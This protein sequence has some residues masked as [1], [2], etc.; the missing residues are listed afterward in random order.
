MIARVPAVLLPLPRPPMLASACDLSLLLF[1]IRR[2]GP[3]LCGVNLRMASDSG[4][5]SAV[6]SLSS[7][8]LPPFVSGCSAC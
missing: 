3:L 8:A 6:V 7:P 5:S 1:S 2:L 4:R